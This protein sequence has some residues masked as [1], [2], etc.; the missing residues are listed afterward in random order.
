MAGSF[1]KKPADTGRRALL[2][3]LAAVPALALAGIL[4]LCSAGEAASGA[5]AGRGKRRRPT[6]AV[7]GA[8]AFGGWSALTLLRKG[9]RVTLLDTWGPGNSRASSGG[10]SRVIRATYGPDAIYVRMVARS[11]SLWQ[12]FERRREQKLYHRT[13]VVWFAGEKDDYERASLPLLRQ[14]GIEFEELTTD[15]LVKRYPQINLEGIRWGIFEPDAGYLLARQACAAV[16]E[17][18]L[19][20][21]G[22]YR[23]MAVEPG[24]IRDG[25]MQSLRLSDGSAHQADQYVFACGPWLGTLFP[26]VI[27]ERIRPTRQEIFFFGTPSGDGR[28]SEGRMPVWIDNGSRVFYGIPGT[29]RRGFK[30][31]DNALGS[32]FDPTSGDRAISRGGLMAARRYL[33]FRF[34]GMKGAPLLE[35]RVCQYENSRD[36][37]FIIDHHPRSENAWIIGGGSGHGFKHGPAVGE[38]VAGMVM[39]EMPVDPFFKLSGES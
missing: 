36:R 18:F 19:A 4:P 37:H 23:Q 24:S 27:G 6:V 1:R 34:P 5:S 29:E 3:A 15:Q 26:E 25:E 35:S 8:G 32:R 28:Y 2:K 38:M 21:G 22:E 33:E 9:V 12:E 20:E 30:I 14:A 13:G 11:L 16:L 39:G 7:V 17:Q 31:A 10:E